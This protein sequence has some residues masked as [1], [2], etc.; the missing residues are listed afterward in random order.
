MRYIK[1]FIKGQLEPKADWLPDPLKGDPGRGPSISGFEGPAVKDDHINGRAVA[2][3]QVTDLYNVRY[4]PEVDELTKTITGRVFVLIPDTAKNRARI[5]ANLYPKVKTGTFLLPKD[6]PQTTMATM[7][8]V[9][10]VEFTPVDEGEPEVAENLDEPKTSEE[11]QDQKS[12]EAPKALDISSLH[13]KTREKLMREGKLP[14]EPVK[15][16][17]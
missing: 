7:E 5:Q 9:E 17:G 11:L 1:L 3:G 10:E 16:E 12:E 4:V 15:L 2:R 8:V 14:Q 6:A 13:W